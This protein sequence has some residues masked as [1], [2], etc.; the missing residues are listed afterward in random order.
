MSPEFYVV[1]DRVHGEVRYHAFSPEL[2]SENIPC[3]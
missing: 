2:Y 1:Q 3:V